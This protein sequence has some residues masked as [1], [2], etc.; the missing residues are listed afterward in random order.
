M[1]TPQDLEA[2]LAATA[3]ALEAGDPLAAEQ[4]S[5]QLAA[6]CADLGGR[7]TRLPAE[8]LARAAALQ[9]RCEA[10]AARQLER[11]GGELDLA[12]RSRRAG[13]AYRQG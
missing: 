6:I 4:A 3:A 9:A 2:A 11:L 10:A 13:Q 7:G 8:G 5:D 12:A 1:A